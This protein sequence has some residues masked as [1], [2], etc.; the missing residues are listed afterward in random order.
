MFKSKIYFKLNFADNGTQHQDMILCQ[1]VSCRIMWLMQIPL[2]NQ[3]R[4]KFTMKLSGRNC[5]KS[6]WKNKCWRNHS[7]QLKGVILLFHRRGMYN[8]IVVKQFFVN[9]SHLQI[10]FKKY[11]SYIYHALIFKEGEGITI[12]CPLSPLQ[13]IY[14]PTKHPVYIWCLLSFPSI[15]LS[16]NHPVYE[17]YI[18]VF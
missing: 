12:W 6:K 13:F 8:K 10:V 11:L 9:I 7:Y 14:Q 17:N 3:Y 1:V 4:K 16:T 2:R 5:F 18:N 15:Y